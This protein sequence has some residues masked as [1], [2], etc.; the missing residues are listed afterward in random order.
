MFKGERKIDS[1][2]K[3]YRY[4]SDT[5][6]AFMHRWYHNNASEIFDRTQRN[7]RFK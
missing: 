2:E 1:M 6:C 7:Y 3:A 5:I 4:F